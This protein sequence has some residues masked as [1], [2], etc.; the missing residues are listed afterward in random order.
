MIIETGLRTSMTIENVTPAR[1]CEPS[2]ACTARSGPGRLAL[3]ERGT[4]M[5]SFVWLG[6]RLYEYEGRYRADYLW[7][8]KRKHSY[9][10]LVECSGCGMPRFT[11]AAS[12]KKSHGKNYC[13]K[14]QTKHVS[15]LLGRSGRRLKYKTYGP[16]TIYAPHHPGASKGYVYEHRI[17]V[18]KDIGRFL[19][20][21]EF[22]HHIDCDDTNNKLDNLFVVSSSQHKRIHAGFE[23][24]IK[25]LLAMKVLRFNKKTPGYEVIGEN[26]AHTRY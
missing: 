15:T 10:V 23:T 12:I 16:I 18:E 13:R 5:K 6:H 8:G 26:N 11:M 20:P 17:V 25:Q 1:P 24:C 3:L 2:P 7:R 22:V 14:C 19:L 4:A 21:N 9:W